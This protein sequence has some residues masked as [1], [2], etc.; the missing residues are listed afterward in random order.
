MEVFVDV[1]GEVVKHFAD[2]VLLHLWKRQN[3]QSC[4]TGLG[5]E[6]CS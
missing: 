5:F 2:V 4:W 6:Y 1:V 3:H